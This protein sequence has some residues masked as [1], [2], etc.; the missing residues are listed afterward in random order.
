MADEIKTTAYGEITRFDLSRKI[1][2]RGRYWTTAYLVDGLMID[3]GCAH[4][5]AE[6]GRALHNEQLSQI[7][8]THSHED[9]IGANALLKSVKNSVGIFAH[10]AALPILADP[11]TYQP[12]QAY[13]RWFWGWPDRSTAQSLEQGSVIET[14]RY[15]FEVLFTPGHSQ[16]HICLYEPNQ[17]WLFSGDAFI[18][19]KDRALLAGSDIWKMIDSLKILAGLPAAI[20]YPGCAQVR[21]D[22][23]QELS[24]KIEYYQEIGEKVLLLHKAGAKVS[25]IANM[26]FGRPMLI[27]LFTW[28]HFSRRRLVLSYLGMNNDGFRNSS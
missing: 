23:K 13:R 21:K 14:D 9:H 6:L 28:G 26:L 17:G 24:Y 8:N 11:R 25:E 12:L 10:P 19:G 18:G 20:M 4:T 1:A 5:A 27:E 7:V 22:P 15:S 2:G 3:T 16:D